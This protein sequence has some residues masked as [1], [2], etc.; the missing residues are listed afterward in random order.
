MLAVKCF[1]FDEIAE[2]KD[3]VPTSPALETE[4]LYFIPTSCIAEAVTQVAVPKC[5]KHDMEGPSL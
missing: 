2:F 1:R 5:L 3:Y 4:I